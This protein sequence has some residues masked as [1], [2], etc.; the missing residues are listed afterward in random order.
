MARDRIDLDTR[1]NKKI[2]SVLLPI[3]N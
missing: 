1:T 2:N 3:E